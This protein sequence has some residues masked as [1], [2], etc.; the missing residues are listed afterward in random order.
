MKREY[1]TDLEIAR[2]K[3]ADMFRLREELEIEIAKQQRNVAALATLSDESEETDDLF[4][5]SLGS[6]TN[7]CRS[8]FRASRNGIL[9]PVEIRDQLALLRFPINQYQN[10]L[11][12]IHNTLKRLEA[13]GEV[14]EVI[15]ND[16]SAYEWIGEAYGGLGLKAALRKIAEKKK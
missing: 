5:M 4:E 1:K 3:L 15:Q 11:A 2:E 9:T 14:K 7:A 6:L 8:V 13:K 12:S 10:I 16:E